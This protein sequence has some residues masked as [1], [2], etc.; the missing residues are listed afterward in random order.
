MSVLVTGAGRGVGRAVA[1]AFAP[2]REVAL[3]ARTADELEQTAELVRAAGG[4]PFVAVADL[5]DANALREAFADVTAT[6]GPIDVL[7]NNAGTGG[8]HIELADGDASGWRAVFE[9]NVLAPATM[10]ALVLPGMVARGRG[11]VV[12][13]ASLQGSRAFNGSSAY[14]ASKAAL[15]RLTDSL[16][17]ELVGTGVVAFDVS[18][19][20]VRTAMTRE[21]HLAA[22]LADVDEQDWSPAARTGEVLLALTSGRFDGLSGCFVHA[23]DDLEDLLVRMT[24]AEP[25]WRRLRMTPAGAQDPLFAD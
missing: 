18:P 8:G 13:I 19:G 21:P 2:G 23:E 20:L 25:D 17:N 7:V 3:L 16:A 14:G 5:T 9:V 22:M 11:Y 1:E 15:M 24:D 12:N 10:C 6:M 4:T